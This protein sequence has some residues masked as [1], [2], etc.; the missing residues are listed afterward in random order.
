MSPD[1][2]HNQGTSRLRSAVKGLV[3]YLEYERDEGRTHVEIS[4]ATIEGAAGVSPSIAPGERE[5]DSGTRSGEGRSQEVKAELDRIAE[6]VGACTKCPLHGSR[7]NV[8]PGQGSP[9]PEIMFV[10]EAPGY[11]ED[12]QG[13]AFVGAAG[14]LLT[15][16]I[17]AMGFRREDVFI[18]NILK[19]RPPGN[20]MPLPDEMSACMPYLKAQIAALKPKVI[21]ALGGTATKGLLDVSVGITKVRGKWM[22]FEGIDTMPTYHPAYLLRSPSAKNAVW[23]DLKEVLKRIGRTPPKKAQ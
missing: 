9:N 20:R 23:D 5:I 7:T 15:K 11:E 17:L 3:Q 13:M 4:P 16:M 19:C 8:V 21:V 12:V 18:G 10:G 14:Q 1:K 6:A 22:V 2:A